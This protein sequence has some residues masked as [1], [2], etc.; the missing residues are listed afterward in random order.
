MKYYTR[1]N[2]FLIDSFVHL[3][4]NEQINYDVSTCGPSEVVTFQKGSNSKKN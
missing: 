3:H 4:F 1:V 2:A